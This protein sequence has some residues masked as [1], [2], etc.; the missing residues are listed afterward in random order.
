MPLPAKILF[1]KNQPGTIDT[2]IADA[3]LASFG[4]FM[5]LP[6]NDV[7][8]TGSDY[9]LKIIQFLLVISLVPWYMGYLLHHFDNY[10][11]VL[12]LIFQW[13]FGLIVL[14]LIVFLIVSMFPMF[15]ADAEPEGLELFLVSFGMFF[16]VL[17]PL[18]LLGGYSDAKALDNSR[19]LTKPIEW[20]I[21]TFT[22]LI[23]TLAIFF[24]IIIVGIFDPKWTGEGSFWIIVL[25]FLGG[26]LVAIL[27]IMPFAFLGKYLEKHDTYRVLPRSIAII[28]PALTF[29]S[30]VWWN[31][32][33]IYNMSPLFEGGKPTSAQLIWSLILAGIIP[34][35]VVMLFKPP[36]NWFHLAVGIIALAIYFMGLTDQ[37]VSR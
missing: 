13:I 2:W 22:I 29:C 33:V 11:R 7:V 37:Y 31:D 27:S 36:L 32:L 17:G 8:L 12:R 20:P 5:L 21:V 24:M 18:M 14:A 15:S 30:L 19:D 3:I 26:P 25:A 4:I 10:P 28:L 1:S 35:R 34:F 9:T 16:T 6:G 23:I